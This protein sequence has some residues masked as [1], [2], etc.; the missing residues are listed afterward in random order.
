M[1]ALHK[2]STAELPVQPGGKLSRMSRICRATFSRIDGN[3]A[4]RLGLGQVRCDK[5]GKRKKTLRES[6]NSIVGHKPRSTRRNH[7]GIYHLCNLG[8]R[9]NPISDDFNGSRIGKHTR[10]ER[11][12]IVDTKNRIKL[13]RNKIGRDSVDCRD[14]M[15]ILRRK[16]GKDRAA[17]KSV[18]M[19]SAKVGLYAG[20]AAGI[21]SGNGKA[22]RRYCTVHDAY[23]ITQ[24][25]GSG[26]RFRR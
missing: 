14:A 19:E 24:R 18:S 21:A 16:R 12:N 5:R 2:H 23:Y 6:C 11:A 1:T 20:V 8:A 10:L 15:R 22:T 26:R 25:Q 4:K 17:V 13:R 9:S 3:T 7:H